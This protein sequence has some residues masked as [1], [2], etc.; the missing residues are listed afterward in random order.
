MFFIFED[1]F[2]HV[3]YWHEDL[4]STFPNSLGIVESILLKINHS[5]M[6]FILTP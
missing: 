3:K 2:P 5:I 6:L 1:S 4:G